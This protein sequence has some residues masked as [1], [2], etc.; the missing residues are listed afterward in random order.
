MYGSAGDFLWGVGLR[1][2]ERRQVREGRWRRH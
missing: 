2:H 1:R